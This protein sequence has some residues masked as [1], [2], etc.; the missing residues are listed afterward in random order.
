MRVYI[1]AWFAKFARQEGIED[2]QLVEA[3]VRANIGL[4]DA[5]LGAGVIKQRISRQGAGKSG[6]FRTIIFFKARNRAIFMFGFAKKAK[7]N[8]THEELLEMKRASREMLQ[9]SQDQIDH[10]VRLKKLQEIR[11]GH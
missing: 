10:L 9:L 8:L 4:I 1:N 5:D 6:G 11:F 3:V 7:K 2:F